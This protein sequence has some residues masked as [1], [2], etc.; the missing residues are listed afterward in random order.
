M[1]LDD[2]VSRE[3]STAAAAAAEAFTA[4]DGQQSWAG[5]VLLKAEAKVAAALF[6]TV[7][8]CR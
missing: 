7:H 6:I 5:P 8:K 3:A 2:D 4:E 1:R